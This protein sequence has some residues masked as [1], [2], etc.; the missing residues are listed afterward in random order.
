MLIGY[1]GYGSRTT[2]TKKIRQPSSGGGNPV[3]T[4]V[5]KI[6]LPHVD[7]YGQGTLPSPTAGCRIRFP[8]SLLMLLHPISRR[9][10]FVKS[11]GDDSV[12]SNAIDSVFIHDIVA[13]HGICR[14]P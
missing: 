2:S 7:P 11:R 5:R 14:T 13:A 4:F 10:R 1:A 3:E 6:A 8:E 9:R 12:V